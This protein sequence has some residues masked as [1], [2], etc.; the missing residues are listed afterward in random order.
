MLDLSGEIGIAR[1][2]LTDML[3]RGASPSREEILAAHREADRLHLELQELIMKARMVPVGPVFHQ[4]VRLVRDL[5]AAQGKQARLAME[6]GDAEV[7]TAIIEAV[8][9]PLTHMIR[10]AVDHG[11]EP[12]EVRRARGKDPCG[13]IVLRAAHEA[14]NIV[15]QVVD[16]GAGLSRARIA[17]RAQALGLV[18]EASK[19][20]DDEIARLVFEPGLSTSEAVT[21]VSG[22]GVGMD[23]VR[24]NVETLRGSVTVESREGEGTSVTIRLPLTLAI[25]QG[26]LVGVAGATYIL[27]LETVVECAELG[28]DAGRG[29][30]GTGVLN[31][32]GKPLPYLRL[33][34]LFGVEAPPPRRENV[35]VVQHGAARAGVAVDVLHGET[36][37]VIKPLGRV[38]QG[39]SGVSGSSILGDG[40]VAL[41]LDVPELLRETLRRSASA[42]A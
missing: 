28:A 4:Y 27:P 14:G 32:R 40:R 30:G 2:R 15:I 36:Q 13:R 8:R 19:L 37:S 1:G 10:N 22:R 31:L 9:D 42:A 17:E 18:R 5:A 16:D 7:D 35:V 21:D 24:R 34:E 38:L 41:I 12:P 6:G 25:I 39:I 11:I 33:R 3:E 26:L 20:S 23:V 29:A